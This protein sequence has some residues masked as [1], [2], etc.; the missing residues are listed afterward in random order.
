L[1]G[2]NSLFALIA[3]LGTVVV[4]ALINLIE[5]GRAD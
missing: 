3:L 2:E 4:V 1:N 5:F